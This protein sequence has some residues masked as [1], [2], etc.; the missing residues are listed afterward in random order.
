MSVTFT[1]PD[2]ITTS[3]VV[4]TDSDPGELPSAVR[5]RLTGPFAKAAGERLGT[6][7]L[8]ITGFR[9]AGSPWNLDSV[10]GADLE[11]AGRAREAGRHIGVT[12]T[13]E[14][15]DLPFGV[16]VARSVTRAIAAAVSGIPVDLD[17][18]RVLRA[19]PDPRDAEATGF[20]LADDWF[21]A[22]APLSPTRGQC[23]A[24]EEEING[25]AC[26]E[27]TTRGLRRFGIPELRI[28]DVAC[29]HDLAALNVLRTTAQRLL[30]LGTRPGEHTTGPV[31]SLAGSDFSAYWGSGEP[32]W[33]DG[34][35]PVH[36]SQLEPLLLGVGPPADFPDTMN[37]WLWDDLPPILYELLSCDPDPAHLSF[38]P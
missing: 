31:L 35:V 19:R 14:V 34:T 22:R 30:P 29:A 37:D 17:T 24:D 23:T 2:K 33:D 18:G 16:Q 13:L 26:V 28:A 12:A 36:L 27:L 10:V 1:V 3:F 20:V 9:A 5:H 32:M 11:E 38:T 8:E 25:C 15:A 21:C 6:P 4:A 7:R